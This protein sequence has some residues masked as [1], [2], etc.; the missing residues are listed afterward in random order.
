M[1]T[2][3]AAQE[4]LGLLLVIAQESMPEGQ[5]QDGWED[6]REKFDKAMDEMFLALEKKRK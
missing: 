3:N 4:T 6:A 5:I 2:Q 1:P